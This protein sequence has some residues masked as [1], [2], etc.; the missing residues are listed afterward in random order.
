M[1]TD[2]VTV[3]IL[4]DTSVLAAIQINWHSYQGRYSP[5]GTSHGECILWCCI[6]YVF[7]WLHLG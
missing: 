7:L 5:S 4:A 3:S 6:Q 2:F 1:P